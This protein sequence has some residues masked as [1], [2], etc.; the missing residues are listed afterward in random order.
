MAAGH[1]GK[2]R[3]CG[4]WPKETFFALE[5]D[6]V[7]FFLLGPKGFFWGGKWAK[8]FFWEPKET[9]N[10][11]KK[12]GNRGAGNGLFGLLEAFLDDWTAAWLDIYEQWEA[13]PVSGHDAEWA[14]RLATM[15][16]LAGAACYEDGANDAGA[17]GWRRLAERYRGGG[18]GMA[19]GND[20]RETARGLP[21]ETRTR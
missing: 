12:Q 11:Q 2:R 8:G 16:L 3:I 1:P 7:S 10:P 17:G 19:G 5:S 14:D 13:D 4:F 20:D 18:G 9:I 15:A 21:W 6:L